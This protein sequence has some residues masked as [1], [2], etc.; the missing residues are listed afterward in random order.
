MKKNNTLIITTI[1]FLTLVSCALIGIMIMGIR[2]DFSH[3]F[4][5][6]EREERMIYQKT[7]NTDMIENININA[8]T[9]D[10][11]IRSTSENEIKVRIYGE[12]EDLATSTLKDRQLNIKKSSE[13]HFC[14][15]FC[16]Y[17]TEK[18][19][20]YIPEKFSGILNITTNTGDINIED[21]ENLNLIIDSD[22]GDIEIGKIKNSKIESNI[23]DVD[24]DEI[25]ENANIKTDTGDITI[26]KFIVKA[27]S[28]IETGIGD[29]SVLHI[30]DAY[31]DAS[32]NIG[33][34]SIKR[35]NRHAK[36]DLK[37]TSDTG[38]ITVK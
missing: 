33:E 26:K 1:V 10:M 13:H 31:I 9:S 2:N 4:F 5:Y 18:V 21:F 38:D 8:K 35:N 23:G 20:L 14:F 17:Q 6:S 29:V 12:D 11:Y 27:N 15:G 3:S 37:I 7:Y 32:T 28:T 16:S 34:V 36:Y 19:V 25:I 24:I 30:S 22:V